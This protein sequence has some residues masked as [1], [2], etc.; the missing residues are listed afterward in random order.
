MKDA[1]N[2]QH[3][4]NHGSG[5]EAIEICEHL[6]F[7]IGNAVK[8][9]WRVDKKDDALQDLNKSAWYLKRAVENRRLGYGLLLRAV[10]NEA[11]LNKVISSETP[12]S[13][14]RDVLELVVQRYTQHSEPRLADALARAEREIA[15]RL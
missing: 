5:V 3:Y 6:D 14:L 15:S 13:V 1:I 8:Y 2:P 11:A 9:L 7:N 10:P 4:R 12:G